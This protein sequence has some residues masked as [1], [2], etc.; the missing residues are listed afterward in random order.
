MFW[1]VLTVYMHITIIVPWICIRKR[2]YA[3]RFKQY[4]CIYTPGFSWDIVPISDAQTNNSSSCDPR[5]TDAGSEL[6]ALTSVDGF[7]HCCACLTTDLGCD[8]GECNHYNERKSCNATAAENAK[9]CLLF[10]RLK[11]HIVGNPKKV[12]QWPLLPWQW[13]P[14]DEDRAGSILAVFILEQDRSKMKQC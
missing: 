14:N 10:R 1:H 13:R 9:L 5:I 12:S 7:S 3:H 11:K 2:S 6:T 4:I 8:A